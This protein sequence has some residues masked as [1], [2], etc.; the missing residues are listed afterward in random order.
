MRAPTITAL[1]A[2]PAL[3]LTSFAASTAVTTPVGFVKQDFAPGYTVA[4]SSLLPDKVY[5]G[6]IGGFSGN[7]TMTFSGT[8]F[9]A[10]TFN[11]GANDPTH[12]VEVLTGSNAGLMLD[13]V[14][15]TT[16]EV[17]VAMDISGLGLSTSDQIAIRPFTTLGS[18]FS[19]TT[20]VAFDAWISLFRSDGSSD[21][22]FRTDTGWSPDGSTPAND[23]IIRPGEG[24]LLWTGT[25][26]EGVNI[27]SVKTGQTKVPA[28]G[29]NVIN[30]VSTLDP[31][32]PKT[33][34]D[35]GL[36]TAADPFDTLIYVFSADGALTLDALMQ[37]DGSNFNN[38]LTGLPADDWEIPSGSAVV[39]NRVS[40]GDAMLTLP[41][42]Y[43]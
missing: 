34:A 5:E 4:S 32:S 25:G 31:S 12:F 11:E 21:L 18:L 10:G 41:S 38:L 24:Y 29:P 16:N 23:R 37:Y 33:L 8:P 9:S 26:G 13:V 20:L 1:L 17:T 42:V 43:N 40:G 28:F 36:A 22:F 2:I 39:F 15:N 7:S 30:L 6:L 27:G 14:S 35:S 19:D 3:S